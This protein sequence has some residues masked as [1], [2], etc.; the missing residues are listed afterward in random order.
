MS[1]EMAVETLTVMEKTIMYRLTRLL[2]LWQKTPEY[3]TVHLKG[4][5]T[6]VI[7]DTLLIGSNT[8]LEGDSTAVIKLANHAGWATMKP[9]DSADEQFRKR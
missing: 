5:F 9:L 6:Y 7:D 3:T 4:P 8:I 1:P 2:S